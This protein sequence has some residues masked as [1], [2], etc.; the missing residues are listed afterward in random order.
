MRLLA[1]VLALLIGAIGAVGVASPSLLIDLV[2][3]L[4][5]PTALLVVAAVRVF[6]GVVLLSVARVSRWPRTFRVLGILIVAAGLLTAFI[7]T[8]RAQAMVEW[9]SG[10]P[11]WFTRAWALLAVAFGGFVVHALVSRRQ[12]AA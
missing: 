12:E 4:L 11:D 7:G 8:E 9:W 10:K 6:Y 2:R 1:I 3:P 5:A